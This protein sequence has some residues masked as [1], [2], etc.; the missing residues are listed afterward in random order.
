[1]SGMQ[2]AES[3]VLRVTAQQGELLEHLGLGNG[4]ETKVLVRNVNNQQV[5]A[6]SMKH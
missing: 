6:Q 3:S 4:K 2:S 5:K 1:M